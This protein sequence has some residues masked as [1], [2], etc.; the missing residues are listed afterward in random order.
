MRV[1]VQLERTEPAH[2][3]LRGV[4]AVDAYDETFRASR[5][6][7]TLG[8]EHRVALSE[9]VELRRIDG[10]RGRHR[11]VRH[12]LPEQLARA[13]DEVPPPAV[14]MKADDVVRD[15]PLVDRAA[16]RP[17][18]HAPAVGL[19]PRNVHEVHERCVGPLLPDQTWCE[20]EVVIVGENGCLRRALELRQHRG[21]KPGV[22]CRVP[23]APGSVERTIDL[24]RVREL[25]QR[26]LDEPQHRIRDDVVVPVVGLLVVSDQVQ[27]VGRAVCG[28][29]IHRHAGT[30]AVLLARRARD[31]GDV[32]VVQEAAKCCGEPAAAP[33]DGA[34]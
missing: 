24:R 1:E 15:Q 13:V 7:L 23:I 22:D 21:C 28:G 32:V 34:V 20:V 5:D 27:P 14:G 9:R 29:L 26:M 12:V 17:R 2:D 30:T 4:G 18:Q 8:C 3:V 33:T 10:D 11:L 25:P 31:P 6:D 16:H 19:R